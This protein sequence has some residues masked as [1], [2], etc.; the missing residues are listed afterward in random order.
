MTGTTQ[1]QIESRKQQ[2]NAI[3]NNVKSNLLSAPHAYRP[4]LTTLTQNA[5][6]TIREQFTAWGILNTDNTPVALTAAQ[7]YQAFIS[8]LLGKLNEA[9]TYK[10]Q[11][12]INFCLQAHALL[13]NVDNTKLKTKMSENLLAVQKTTTGNV[14]RGGDDVLEKLSPGSNHP[15]RV[16]NIA[17]L[18]EICKRIQTKILARMSTHPHDALQDAI[19]Y[20]HLIKK[21][22]KEDNLNQW[23]VAFLTALSPLL[24]KF[25]TLGIQS[26]HGSLISP[27]MTKAADW[28]REEQARL[29]REQA[30]RARQDSEDTTFYLCNTS[31]I[32]GTLHFVTSLMPGEYSV[33]LYLAILP[34]FP[35]AANFVMTGYRTPDEAVDAGMRVAERIRCNDTLR[36]VGWQGYRAV[37]A[38]A[39]RAS[40][41][42]ERLLDR[43][44]VNLG[45][46][47][48][49]G[50]LESNTPG[51]RQI[52]ELGDDGAG[53]SASG[54][55]AL[56]QR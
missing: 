12:A 41:A 38:G 14:F 22:S 47:P 2:T 3:L 43:E 39:E 50:A 51:A 32:L 15:A 44:Q 4:F 26:T 54:A 27:E 28:E 49:A 25:I 48:R 40:A 34:L 29:A 19:E 10:N 6:G 1:Q 56:R 36:R 42:L 55:L 5:G 17:H 24:G 21:M 45:E 31:A 13:G 8:T 46:P 33:P 37:H 53:A 35:A 52:T 9:S 11:P 7:Q 23:P 16:M 20:Q 30:A 18:R